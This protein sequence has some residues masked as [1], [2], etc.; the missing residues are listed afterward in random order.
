MSI[1]NHYEV[2]AEYESIHSVD[3]I[4]GNVPAQIKT[5]ALKI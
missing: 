5:F 3:I 1:I 2:V 4:S